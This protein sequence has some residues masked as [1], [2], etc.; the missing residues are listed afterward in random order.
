MQVEILSAAPLPGGVKVARRFVKPH[1][2]GASPTL[3]ATQQLIVH[4]RELRD[5]ATIRLFCPSLNHQLSTLNQFRKAGRYKLAAPVS[6]TGSAHAEVGALPTP[7]A[8]FDSRLM[9]FDP[10]FVNRKSQIV[11][12]PS[13]SSIAERP[14]DNRKTAERYRAGRPAFASRASARRAHSH[15]AVAHSAKADPE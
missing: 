12:C 5:A 3:A 10:P 4:S 14:V 7:S 9:R 6:K 11:N 8:N 1:G 15:R 13:C 2:V